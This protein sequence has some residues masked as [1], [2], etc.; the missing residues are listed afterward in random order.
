VT[1][2]RAT[3]PA[4]VIA[5]LCLTAPVLGQQ[6]PSPAAPL[7][8]ASAAVLDEWDTDRLMDDVEA[9][10]VETLPRLQA[11]AESGDAR[12]Q[13]L[14]GLSHEFGEGGLARQ[15]QEGLEWFL[16]AA[17]QGIAW[18]EAWAA[19]FYM[20]GTVGVS[21]D[22][23][24][25]LTLYTAAASRG[26]SRAAFMLGQIYFHGEGAAASMPDAARWFRRADSEEGSLAVLMAELAEVPCDTEF[27]GTLRRVLGGMT[28]AS[29]GRFVDAW[30]GAAR[31]WSA[32]ITLPGSDRCGFTSSD[33]TEAGELRTFFCDSPRVDDEARGVALAKALA[34]Q[35]EKVLPS[36]Y[37]R[38]ER[39][40]DPGPSTFFARE[41]YPQLRVTYN[42]TPGSAQHR[43]T[44]LVGR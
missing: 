28:S 39:A 2:R 36:G 38:T 26:E 3:F 4:S 22:P 41:G 29:A 42:L 18:A 9:L 44:L 13:V 17:A 43:V 16:K 40:E 20:N 7:D 35:V 12:S 33:R 34:D 5:A 21:R 19:D 31:E 32:A 25:A 10:T 30:D 1:A 15:P 24:R 6:S 37:T 8:S 27:C 11:R 14:L 23:S